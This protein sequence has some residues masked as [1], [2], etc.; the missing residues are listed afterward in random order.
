LLP[1]LRQLILTVADVL[2][3]SLQVKAS[4]KLSP[5]AKKAPKVPKKK[6]VKAKKPKTVKPKVKVNIA[7]PPNQ[8][9]PLPET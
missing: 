3:L 6:V 1:A 2:V 5:A 7:Q 9:F 8:P 4:Y